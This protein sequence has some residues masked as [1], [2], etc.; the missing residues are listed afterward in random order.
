M[1]A[2]CK[3]LESLILFKIDSSSDFW[4]SKFRVV[5]IFNPPDSINEEGIFFRVFNSS[6]TASW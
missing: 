2:T 5:Y 3:L 1:L 6:I 4:A